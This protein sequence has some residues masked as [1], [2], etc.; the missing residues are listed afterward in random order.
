VINFVSNLPHDL[1]S[2]GFSAMNA[3]AFTTLRKHAVVHYAGPINPP[4]F[5]P[6][7]ALSKF[8][9]VAGSQ[10]DFFFFSRRR[11][12]VIA[13]EVRARCRADARLDFFH[14]FTPWVLTRPQ[15]PYIAYSDCTFRDYI[16]IFHR[17]E[18]FRDRDLQ[19]IEQAEAEWLKNAR[20]VLLRSEWAANRAVSDY[21]LDARRVASVGGFGEIEVPARDAY[22]GGKQFAFVSTNFA[23]KGGAVVLSA[24]RRVR[25]RHPDA[26]LAII[27]DR[28]AH[29]VAEPGVEFLGYLRKEVPGEVE[30]LRQ[31]LSLARALVHPTTGDVS[32]LIIVE[33]GYFGC[34]AI[35]SRRFAI[36][37]VVQDGRTGL[38]LDD[39]SQVDAVA[40]AMN[41]M[42][43][44]DEQYLRMRHAVW[45]KAHGQHSKRRFEE[46][47]LSFVSGVVSGVGIPAS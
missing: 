3:S 23:A 41:W 1:R 16:G 35:S 44:A 21:A 28:P 4:V 33:A 19:R 36:P 34:P 40:S 43:E 29:A 22:A 42:L 25:Q 31:I 38:L 20:L 37:E 18:Q 13:H 7:K 5:L 45:A 27:G 24:F 46:R 8:L 15:R 11:L 47:F 10:G 14:G 9:R 12:Q 30:R 32:P 26:S 6:Q 2:G 17:R 39:P